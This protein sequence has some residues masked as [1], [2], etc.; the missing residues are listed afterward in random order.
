MFYVL[1]EKEKETLDLFLRLVDN[2]GYS[3]SL[4]LKKCLNSFIYFGSR[5]RI[6][7]YFF[8]AHAYYK[9][10]RYLQSIKV[11]LIWLKFT[12]KD[13]WLFLQFIISYT[14]DFIIEDFSEILSID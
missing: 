11:Y 1:N 9:Y 5:L 13:Y 12:V 4:N 6:Y 2:L 10:V 14:S 7:D 8:N 3:I